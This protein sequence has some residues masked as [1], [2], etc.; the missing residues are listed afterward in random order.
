MQRQSGILLLFATW[1]HRSFRW[2]QLERRWLGDE[3]GSGRYRARGLHLPGYVN[4]RFLGTDISPGRNRSRQESEQGAAVSEPVREEVRVS[5][6]KKFAG[7]QT[8]IEN[9]VF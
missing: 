9:F 4:H 2:Y 7:W 3:G 6:V 1:R 8:F 5:T